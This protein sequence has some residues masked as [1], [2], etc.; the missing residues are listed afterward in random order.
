MVTHLP[1]FFA[2]GSW[3]TLDVLNHLWQST[4]AGVAVLG[5][6]LVCAP[7][8]A[9]TRRSLGLMAMAKFAIPVAVITAVA[10]R[11]FGKSERW[12][13]SPALTL[14]VNFS[15]PPFVP[16]APISPAQIPPPAHLPVGLLLGVAWA[17]GFA[18]TFGWWLVRGWRLR[19]RILASAGPVPATMERRIARAAGRVGLRRIPRCATVADT[20][21]AGVLGVFS[22]VVILPRGLEDT[23]T[24]AELEA[25]LIHEFVHVKRR[26]NLWGALQYLLVSLFWFHPVVRLLNRRVGLEAEK[27]CDERVLEITGDPEV[28]AGGLI[29]CVRHALG[30]SQPSLAGVTTPPVVARMQNILAHRTRRDRPIVR[31]A[32]LVTGIAL[33]GF[34]GCAGTFANGKLA[35]VSS[36]KP[37]VSP[38]ASATVT[39]VVAPPR[40]PIIAGEDRPIP[41]YQYNQQTGGFEVSGFDYQKSVTVDYAD[42]DVRNIVRQV[43]DHF[44]LNIIVPDT[45]QAKASI[46]ASSQTW[47]EIFKTVLSPAGYTFI[48]DRGI[49]KIARAPSQSA[50]I[51]GAIPFYVLQPDDVIRVLVAGEADLN[52]AGGV[53]LAS[54]SSVTLPLIGRV[55]LKDCTV[56]QAQERISSRY[57]GKLSRKP[58]VWINVVEYHRRAV[59]DIGTP[60]PKK[61]PDKDTLSVDFPDENIRNIIQNVAD[62]FALR[63]VMPDTL[64][65]K[66]TIKLR[67]VTWRQ[68][69]QGV[70]EPV[71]YTFVEDGRVVNIVPVEKLA[72]TQAKTDYVAQPAE[73]LKAEADAAQ[74]RIDAAQGSPGAEVKFAPAEAPREMARIDLEHQAEVAAASAAVIEARKRAED[75][76]AAAKADA[77][78]FAAMDAERNTEARQK[79]ALKE[80]A[81]A[82]QKM[83]SLDVVN[84]RLKASNQKMLPSG[85]MVALDGASAGSGPGSISIEKTVQMPS[86]LPQLSDAELA[87]TVVQRSP[88]SNF[89]GVQVFDISK[90]DQTPVPK[91][92]AKPQYPFEMRRA[93]IG[94]EVTV[95]FIIDTNG[96]VQNAYASKSSQREFE[97]AAVQAVSKWKFRPGRKGG[98]DVITHMVVPIVFTTKS[99]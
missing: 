96:D 26:D 94:G 27:S 49:I 54:D 90:L 25:V 58:P 75:V 89:R 23:L 1:R 68:I 32:A 30:V 98:K 56:P 34:S 38:A 64:R 13:E 83:I 77:A 87:K 10:T 28:Y 67:D 5:L 81:A 86:T 88:M 35:A 84:E 50:A 79:R 97:A 31:G 62:L 51:A 14:P 11:F 20:H 42:E 47:R 63:V 59:A 19:R 70:L 85:E 37:A 8:S 72:A 41:K 82:Q 24:L 7:L 74:R 71:G 99:G 6:L 66:I 3:T 76:A 12:L 48:E 33:L 45:L 92:Q 16:S 95:D 80:Q 55:D 60:S 57:E 36:T 61:T 2:F 91:Y 39:S 78:R 18:A 53:R 46:K 9:R 4:A 93:G 65:G 29:K 40:V 52:P 21:D 15:P 43:A 69:F 17:V 73:R 44:E 22:P